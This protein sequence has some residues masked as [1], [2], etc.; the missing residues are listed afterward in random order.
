MRINYSYEYVLKFSSNSMS[1]S[2]LLFSCIEF[3]GFLYGDPCFV[4]FYS[5]G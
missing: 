5:L 4:F 1:L 3:S 2:L